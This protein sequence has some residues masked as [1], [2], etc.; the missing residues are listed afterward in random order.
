MGRAGMRISCMDLGYRIDNGIL[1]PYN[2][3]SRD[4]NSVFGNVYPL[5]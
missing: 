4:K 1:E 2:D 3:N 5:G